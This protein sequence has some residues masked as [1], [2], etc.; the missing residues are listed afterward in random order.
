MIQDTSADRRRLC[1][2]R[3]KAQMPYSARLLPGVKVLSGSSL[4]LIGVKGKTI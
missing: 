1:K 3:L 4:I 2:G